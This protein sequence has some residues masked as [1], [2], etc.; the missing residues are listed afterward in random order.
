[1]LNSEF[2]IHGRL[3]DKHVSHMKGSQQA[4]TGEYGATRGKSKTAGPR[5]MLTRGRVQTGDSSIKCRVQ[6]WIYVF[7]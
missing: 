2:H 4:T 6:V 3:A 7:I 1:M 5:N